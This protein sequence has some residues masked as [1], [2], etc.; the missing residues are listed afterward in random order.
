[1]LVPEPAEV[2]NKLIVFLIWCVHMCCGLSKKPCAL[3]QATRSLD[4]GMVI[5]EELRHGGS[6]GIK[7]LRVL[8][9]T[10]VNCLMDTLDV[11]TGDRNE[12]SVF[13]TSGTERRKEIHN[14][15]KDY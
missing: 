2:E 14:S 12:K 15:F 5:R 9:G 6:Q 1:M 7:E 13:S 11:S 10:S 3:F 8:S 4:S